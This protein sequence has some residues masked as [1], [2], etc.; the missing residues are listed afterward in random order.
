VERRVRLSQLILALAILI[1][2]GRLVTGSFDFVITDFWFAAGLLLLILLSLVDQPFFSTEANVFVNSVTAWMSL[3]LISRT[4]RSA[5]WT[6]FL[7]ASTFLV[8]ASY[9]LM[10]IRHIDAVKNHRYVIF[11]SR[12][13]T[14]IGRPEVIF[15]AFFIWGVSR[16]FGLDSSKANAF[17]LFW[18]IF[19]VINTPS[20]ARGIAALL[21]KSAAARPEP[22]G[23]LLSYHHPG[24]C[25]LSLTSKAPALVTGSVL[26]LR[27]ANT[28]V[29]VGLVLDDRPVAGKRIARM[30]VVAK[31]FQVNRIV[32]NEESPV[33]VYTDSTKLDFGEGAPI[34]VVDSGTE[35]G[36]L[37][38][39]VPPSLQMKEGEVVWVAIDEK[40]RGYYQVVSATLIDRSLSGGNQVYYIRVVAGQLGR[41]LETEAKFAPLAWVPQAGSLVYRTTKDTIKAA[42][43]P[44]GH[45]AIGSVP[46]SEFPVHIELSDIVTHN[47]AIIGV[48]GSGKS[49]LALRVV[50][51][52]ARTGVKILVLDLSRE[53]WLFLEKHNSL[54]AL[55]TEADVPPWLA[56]ADSMIG[57]YQFGNEKTSYPKATASFV[58]KVFDWASAIQLRPGKNVPARVCVVLEEA[59][60]LIPEW[61]QVSQEN[62]K[63]QV[64]ST[65]RFLLQGRKFGMGTIVITQR[66]ANVTKTILNQCNTIF[67]LQSFDQTGLEFLKNYMGEEYSHTISTLPTRHA[68]LVGKASSSTR[69]I[70]FEIVD[71]EKYFERP[72]T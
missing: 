5:L 45:L 4:E 70:L 68:V 67:A 44:K 34:S 38:F 47:C 1:V 40:N 16:K 66:T 28:S 43:I 3:L 23:Q 54:T 63:Q 8:V 72:E 21:K 15:S 20:I 36:K 57:I 52:L 32:D 6:T 22:I 55:K 24:I 69:P 27:Q 31:S 25:V 62:D 19:I 56:N 11:A 59:H 9:A 50:E 46:N 33:S 71:L 12:A 13:L 37:C 30:S 2:V 48:T 60:S 53:H 61:N 7:S 49:Y 51:E 64:N 39:L 10:W 29:G 17:L 65:A 35:L 18:A 26:E 14:R 58:S 42:T 41:W